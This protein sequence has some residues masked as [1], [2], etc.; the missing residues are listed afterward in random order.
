MTCNVPPRHPC[1][2]HGCDWCATCR[3][4]G[5][6]GN[7]SQPV[8]SA[9]ASQRLSVSAAAVAL[10]SGQTLSIASLIGLD[11][12]LAAPPHRLTQVERITRA[13]PALPPPAIDLPLAAIRSTTTTTEKGHH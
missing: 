3:A 10:D 7:A 8:V 5:C 1:A 6:C 9:R 11:A 2:D 13:V 12:T 4:G